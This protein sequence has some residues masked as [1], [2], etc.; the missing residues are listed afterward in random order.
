MDAITEWSGAW[1]C[2]WDDSYGPPANPAADYVFRPALEREAGGI[3]LSAAKPADAELER[4]RQEIASRA[5]DATCSAAGSESDYPFSPFACS[6]PEDAVLTPALILDRLGAH[7]QLKDS[8]EPYTPEEEEKQGIFGE[9]SD[10][11]MTMFPDSLFF[12]AGSEKLN[13]IPFF[14]VARLSPT[15]VAGYIGAV[16]H[17]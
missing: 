8:A 3:V 7:Q 9:D 12:Y 2:Y 10:T 15:L 13:P 11:L 16:V 1:I 4:V 17:T 14:W 6:V 5:K